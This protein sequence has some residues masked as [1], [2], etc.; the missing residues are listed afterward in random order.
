MHTH[1]QQ[2]THVA[3]YCLIK[4]ELVSLS[5]EKKSLKTS[6]VFMQHMNFT[7]HLKR[8]R[9]CSHFIKWGINENDNNNDICTYVA[10]N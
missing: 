4:I 3:F 5:R 1:I 10:W 9:T 2:K 8:E 6:L 7:C